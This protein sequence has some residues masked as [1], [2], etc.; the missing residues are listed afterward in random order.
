[1]L[2]RHLKLKCLCRN[3][4]KITKINGNKGSK[5]VFERILVAGETDSFGPN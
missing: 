5:L 1:M 4:N 3:N 2:L